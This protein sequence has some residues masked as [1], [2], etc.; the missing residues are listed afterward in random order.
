MTD[1][2]FMRELMQRTQRWTE[3]LATLRGIHRDGLGRGIEPIAWTAG[4]TVGLWSWFGYYWETERFWFG[5]GS[6]EGAWQPLISADIRNRHAQ[7]WLQL[8]SQ[9]PNVWP[10][11]TAG[12]Y[13]YLWSGLGAADSEAQGRWF[14]DRSMELHE[15]SLMER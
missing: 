15:Y 6:F 5:Y 10:S 7:S 3:V 11:V 4:D 12:E 13:A 8:R 9:L 14:H 2:Q 1:G